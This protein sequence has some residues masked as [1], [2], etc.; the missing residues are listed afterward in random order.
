MTMMV[1]PYLDY[2]HICKNNSNKIIFNLWGIVN[3]WPKI[4]KYPEIG[5]SQ[6]FRKNEGP[7]V[8]PEV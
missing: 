7:I 4:K 6:I 2:K 1:Q 3:K 8:F 5:P